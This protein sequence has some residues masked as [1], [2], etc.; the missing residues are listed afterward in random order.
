GLGH[1]QVVAAVGGLNQAPRLSREAGAVHRVDRRV[2]QRALVL[3]EVLV[4][5][6]GG[7]WRRDHQRSPISSARSVTTTWAPCSV[8]D[9][10]PAPRSTPTTRPKSPAAPAWTPLIASSR[11]TDRAE[12]KPSCSAAYA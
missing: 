8:R 11:T 2:H 6:S 1:A 4:V 3:P 10:A 5:V 9:A 12:G 7:G